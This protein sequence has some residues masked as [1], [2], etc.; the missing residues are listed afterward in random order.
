MKKLFLGLLCF[1]FTMGMVWAYTPTNEESMMVD[2]LSDAF[3][4]AEKYKSEYYVNYLYKKLKTIQIAYVNNY[5]YGMERWEVLISMIM[6]NVE[7]AVPR[8]KN[9]GW[10]MVD[11]AKWNL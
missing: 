9:I 2:N 5:G 4:L 7:Y 6:N 10:D 8:L 11:R 3:V 1:V